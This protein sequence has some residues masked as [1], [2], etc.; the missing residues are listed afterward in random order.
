MVLR[1]R[2][3][4]KPSRKQCL[5]ATDGLIAAQRRN[6]RLPNSH[7]TPRRAI[8]AAAGIS[9]QLKYGEHPGSGMHANM[10]TLA[11]QEHLL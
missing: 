8:R 5:T 1:V 11:Y 6:G 10:H 7:Y 9:P 2:I 4:L 3:G